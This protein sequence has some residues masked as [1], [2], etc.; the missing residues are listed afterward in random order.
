MIKLKIEGMTCG[1]CVAAVTQALESVP[2]TG[3]VV[4]VSLDRAEAV[5]DGAPDSAALI[6]SLQKDGFRAEL[7]E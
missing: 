7:I 2:G 4:E 5:I 1:H 3:K 6:A